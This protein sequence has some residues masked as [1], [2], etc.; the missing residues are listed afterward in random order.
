MCKI[1]LFGVNGQV[2]WELQR[3]LAPLGEVV[4][5]HRDSLEFCG[6]LSN[7]AGVS[8]TVLRFRPDFIV[9][10]AGYT[11]VDKAQSEPELARLLNAEAVSLLAQ[12]ALQVDAWL[13]HYSSDYVFDG[14]GIHARQESEST[15]PVNVY[16]QTK[17]DGEKAIVASGCKYLI[18]RTSWVY[19]TRG[20]NFLKTMLRLAQERKTLEVIDDQYG[21]PTGADLIADVTAH[22]IRRASAIEEP[23]IGGLYHL[24]SA[25]ETSWHEYAKY[26]V[27]QAKAMRPNWRWTVTEIAPIPTSSYQSPA[28]RPKNSRLSTVKV[29]EALNLSMPHWTTGVDRV[30]TEILQTES[31]CK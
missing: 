20:N 11:E 12:L 4:A 1:L 7:F 6:D 5:L 30:L 27:N 23:S 16:G 2:G 21:A 24:V 14:A 17:L 28:V 3:S 10:A 22:A 29:E 15:E 8:D 18:F 13:V 19:A 26:A 9:N 31:L 25:G